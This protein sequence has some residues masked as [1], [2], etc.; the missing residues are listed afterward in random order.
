MLLFLVFYID[1]RDFN[2]FFDNANLFP[3]ITYP[4]CQSQLKEMR[5]KQPSAADEKKLLKGGTKGR[6]DLKVALR[7]GLSCLPKDLCLDSQ[8]VLCFPG[9]FCQLFIKLQ[10]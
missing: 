5:G 2:F 10:K 4:Q 8:R 3:K 1:A 7:A 6:V 9:I